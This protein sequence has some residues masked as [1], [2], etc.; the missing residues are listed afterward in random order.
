MASRTFRTLAEVKGAHAR[1]D[2]LRRARRC[3]PRRRTLGKSAGDL[4]Y[5]PSFWCPQQ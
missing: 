3:R 4:Y 5:A 1:C 2:H